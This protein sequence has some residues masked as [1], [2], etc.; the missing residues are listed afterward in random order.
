MAESISLEGL[1]W[2]NRSSGFFFLWKKMNAIDSDSII[3]I[4]WKQKTH[5]MGFQLKSLFWRLVFF[6]K[7]SLQK[8]IVCDNK[9]QWIQLRNWTTEALPVLLFLFCWNFPCDAFQHSVIP[10]E[11]RSG[12]RT[13]KIAQNQNCDNNRK[14]FIN[15]SYIYLLK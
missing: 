15:H 3:S 7:N 13:R 1:L 12:L 6:S 9:P 4:S 2:N 10:S 5:S 14:I 8:L 11:V